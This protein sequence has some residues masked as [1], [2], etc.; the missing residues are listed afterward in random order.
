MVVPPLALDQ[1]AANPKWKP[2]SRRE[3]HQLFRL[4]RQFETV[5]S[6]QQPL[7]PRYAMGDDDTTIDL[8]GAMA[9]A[10][11]NL[12]ERKSPGAGLESAY[13]Q[14]TAAFADLILTSVDDQGVSLDTEDVKALAKGGMMDKKDTTN[15]SK[16]LFGD[17]IDVFRALSGG[18]HIVKREDGTL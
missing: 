10:R 3:S 8:E 7:L 16:G 11:R 12:E 14:A 1:Q 2:Y 6:I 15:K 13:D 4:R 18:A 5:E 9:A 17:I